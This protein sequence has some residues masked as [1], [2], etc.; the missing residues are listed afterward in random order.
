[1]R[2]P[3]CSEA[4]VIKYCAFIVEIPR[5]VYQVMELLSGPD[6]F[7]YLAS[8]TESI[9][10]STT[11]VLVRQMVTAIHHLHRRVGILHRDIKPENFGF[12]TPFPADGSQG[13]PLLKLFDLGL[14]WVL[15]EAVTDA[16]AMT[17]HDVPRGGTPLYMAPE[18]W[19]AQCGAPSDIWGIGLVAYLLLGL[20]LP[21]GLLGSTDPQNKITQ[22]SLTFSAGFDD[23]SPVARTMVSSMLEKSPQSRSTTTEIL[24]SPWFAAAAA[25]QG[26][27]TA[28]RRR[29]TRPTTA[30]SMAA[31]RSRRT[32]DSAVWH[33]V[34]SMSA[35]V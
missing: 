6:L 27:A 22:N 7:D 29:D 16:D 34:A 5:H 12:V 2:A 13:M 26:A 10:E 28:V 9:P 32:G 18:M 11:A 3:E 15:D 23:V 14:A 8:S 24:A 33:T 21:F 17:M 30:F 31:S 20:D 1:M 35:Q 4:G 25:A 19:Q